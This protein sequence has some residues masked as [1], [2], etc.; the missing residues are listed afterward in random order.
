MTKK[1]KKKKRK[2]KEKKKRAP[3]EGKNFIVI[4][5]I[6]RR[7][8]KNL[9]FKVSNFFSLLCVPHKNQNALKNTRMARTKQTARKSTGTFFSF[10]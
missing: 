2:K 7:R 6:A 5:I 4:I 3:K 8:K 1:K 9:F 10:V